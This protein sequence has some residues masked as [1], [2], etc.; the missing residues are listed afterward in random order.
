MTDSQYVIGVDIGGTHCTAALIDLQQKKIIPSTLSRATINANGKADEI[1]AAWS[2][3]ILSAKQHFTTAS[4]C[5]AMPGPFDYEAG[6]CLMQGQ[7]KYESLYGLNIK[8]LLAAS[9][10]LVPAAIFMDND[11]AC[12]L[13]GEVFGGVANKYANDTVIGVT[14]GT[15]LGS[16]TYKRGLAQ[17]ADLWN[18]PFKDGIAEDYLSTRWFVQQYKQLTG[19]TIKGVKELVQLAETGDMARTVFHDFGN[20]LGQFLLDFINKENPAA[21]VIGG[22]ISKSF[23]LFRDSLRAVRADQYPHI[24]IEQSVLGEEAPLL[25]AAGSWF[26]QRNRNNVKV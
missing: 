26:F 9:L 23:P 24:K 3:C 2:D 22:N 10:Q 20:N 12:F 7:N 11:A 6:I 8:E 17:S 19:D 25:G 5:M 16:A 4:V 21:V 1:I 18:H 15:G 14:L 13:H